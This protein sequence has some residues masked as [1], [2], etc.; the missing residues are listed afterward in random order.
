MIMGD[1]CTRGCRFCAVKTSRKPPDLDPLEPLKTAEAIASW[2][3]DY[4]VITMVNRDDLPDGGAMHFVQT[5]NAVKEKCPKILIECL[6]GDFRGNLDCVSWMVNSPLNVYAHN[7]ETVDDLQRW[8]RDY[9]ANYK[10]SLKVLEHAKK[11]NP[12]KITKTSLMLGHGETEAQ[13]R[14]TFADLR[15]VGV[16][17]ITLGQYLRPTKKHLKVERFLEP[18]EWEYWKAEGERMGFKYVA[19]GPLVRS[20]YKAAEFYLKNILNNN[21]SS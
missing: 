19:S 18:A 12:T 3:V 17:C 9:R 20:S 6:T 2:A 21:P 5:V 4:I 8:V 14:A 11:T 16:D 7:V 13:I 15:N 10:Q 1:Q